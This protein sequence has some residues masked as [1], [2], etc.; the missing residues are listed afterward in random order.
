[1]GANHTGHSLVG[2]VVVV[3][4][5]VD[6]VDVVEVV[7]VATKYVDSEKSDYA[8]RCNKCRLELTRSWRGARCRDLNEAFC[9]QGKCAR[10]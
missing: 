3:V 5:V 7:V 1:M 8:I 9:V 2:S 4:L 6:V 10:I